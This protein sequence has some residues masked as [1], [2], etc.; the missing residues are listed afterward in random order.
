MTPLIKF[1]GVKD[2]YV[3]RPRA[4][5]NGTPNVL[6][7]PTPASRWGKSLIIDDQQ[8]DGR[9]GSSRSASLRTKHDDHDR[10][11]DA[12]HRGLEALKDP[13]VKGAT[14]TACAAN[15]LGLPR[16]TSDTA[17]TSGAR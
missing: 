14:R 13:D 11:H 5:G 6:N 2:Q 9:V 16:T 15:S 1:L 3:N 7:H 8:I 4:R 12:Q 17:P 10:I